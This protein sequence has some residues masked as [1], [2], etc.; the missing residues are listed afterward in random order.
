MEE[1]CDIRVIGIDE[2]RPPRVRKEPYI[3]LYFRLSRQPPQAW[4]EEFNQLA[5]GL[6][7]PVKIDVKAGIFIDA[8]VRSMDDIPAHFENIKMRVSLCNERY[9]ENIREQELAAAA[10]NASLLGEGGEQARL[11]AIVA[12]L[13]FDD[14]QE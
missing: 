4:R 1:I 13:K 3:D 11:N 10:A 12:A 8:Y 5:K 6:V 7:P 2:K 14:R 9:M